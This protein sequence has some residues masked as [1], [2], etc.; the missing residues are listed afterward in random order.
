MQYDVFNFNTYVDNKGLEDDMRRLCEYV[1]QNRNYLNLN[2]S[3]ESNDCIYQQYVQAN[4]SEY[5]KSLPDSQ[6]TPSNVLLY[7]ASQDYTTAKLVG[8]E[9]VKSS[10]ESE[11]VMPIWVCSNFSCRSNVSSLSDD[12]ELA[13]KFQIQVLLK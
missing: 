6:Q 13:G 7:W 1:D 4:T 10:E 5:I 9:Y 8:A 12:T 3:W 2:P 11:V